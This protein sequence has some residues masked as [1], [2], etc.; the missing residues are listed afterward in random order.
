MGKAE[1]LVMGD[2]AIQVKTGKV[3]HKLCKRWCS[4]FNEDDLFYHPCYPPGAD[5]VEMTI[6]EIVRTT[7]LCF[8]NK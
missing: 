1:Y 8:R 7:A 6:P 5:E 4:Y 3:R 2:W